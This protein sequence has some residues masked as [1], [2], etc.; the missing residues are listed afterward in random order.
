MGL[1]NPFFLIIQIFIH[2]NKPD[3]F[4]ADAFLIYHFYKKR[5]LSYR[6]HR[7]NKYCFLTFF[8]MHF[9]FFC[10]FFCHRAENSGIILHYND[11]QLRIVAYKLLS[12]IAVVCMSHINSSF[13]IRLVI[14]FLYVR[15]YDKKQ[16]FSTNLCC[17]FRQTLSYILLSSSVISVIILL[18]INSCIVRFE[19]DIK[20]NCPK[21]KRIHLHG[22]P[23]N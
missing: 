6:T 9:N 11:R 5:I 22:F 2:I 18:S 1:L 8:I 19:Y 16:A 20:R 15:L 4:Q 10:H 13:P 21:S 14:L 7:T 12:A 23:C 17:L 3:I